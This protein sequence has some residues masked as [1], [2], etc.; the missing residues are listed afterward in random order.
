MTSVL[1]PGLSDTAFSRAIDEFKRALGSN[2][3][4]TFGDDL[5]EFRDPYTFAAWDEY[6]ASAVVQ[7]NSVEEI[8]A[9][10]RIANEFRI[11][12][13]TTSQ[14]RNNGY[15]GSAPRVRGSV[16]VNLRR[17]NRVLEVNEE[18]AYAVVEPGVSFFDLYKAVRGGG[19]KLWISVPD[20]GW[21]SVIGNTLEHGIGY[22]VN[23]DHAAAQCGME[24]VLANG[25]VIRTGM[26][27]MANGKSWH[28]YKRGF[29]PSADGLFMQSNF[30]IVTKMGVWLMPEPECYRASWVRVRD[31]SDLGALVD[32][33]RPLVLDKTIPSLPDIG[34]VLAVA[35][36]LSKREELYDGE[37]PIPA[38]LYPA[39]AKK[40]GIGIW[41]VSRIAQYGYEEIVDRQFAIVEKAISKIPGAWVESQKYPGNISPDDVHPGYKVVGGIPVLDQLKLVKWYGGDAGGH[42]DFSPVVPLTGQHVVT[43]DKLVRSL[44]RRSGF[45]CLLGMLLMPRCLVYA[46][47]VP[48]DTT[49]E[50]QTREAFDLCKVLVKEAHAA[51]Y[52]EYRA[53]VDLMDHVAAQFD[54]N[55]HALRR[56]NEAIKDALDP[57][58]ILAPG[59]QGIW[60]RALRNGRELLP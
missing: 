24:V 19:H 1:P 6:V 17:M 51:G 22:T 54:F 53:H 42:V 14:G 21:G 37:G 60:P 12:L 7:P 45:D 30:G 15:G 18:N 38:E 35:S 34:H 58:G 49:N 27:A 32:A 29:G 3:V 28:V 10:L 33:L 39:I 25:D 4:L 57:N 23:G 20:L 2:A 8:Q 56:F 31:D 36:M 9:I 11:P 43:L 44:V 55:N 26:G 59:K 41:N 48:F 50:Q 52:G 46:C 16:I 40:L 5:R 13:W 47:L